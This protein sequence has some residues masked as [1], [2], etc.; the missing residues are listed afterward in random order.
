M[1]KYEKFAKWT[2]NFEYELRIYLDLG[3]SKEKKS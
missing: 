3:R 2:K 1:G